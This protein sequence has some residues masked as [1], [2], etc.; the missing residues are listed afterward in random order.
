MRSIA[1]CFLTALSLAASAIGVIVDPRAATDPT[2]GKLRGVVEN[3]GVC[4]TTPG[5]YQASGYG[6]IS[7][8][9]S[10]WFW[11]FE[12]RHNPETAPLT[13]WIQGEGGTSSMVGLLTKNG[14]CRLND[15]H[16]S[17]SLNP[18]SFNEVSNVLYIDQPVGV[19]FSYGSRNITTTQA[20]AADMWEF[21]QIFFA[22]SRFTKYQKNDFGLWSERYGGN[23][24]STFASYFLTQNDAIDAGTVSGV[25]INVKNVGMGGPYMDPLLQL[26]RFLD[27]AV[28]NPYAQLVSASTILQ[29]TRLWFAD[30]NSGIMKKVQSCYAGNTSNNQLVC[31]DA[32]LAAE[33]NYYRG[34]AGSFQ[35][36]HVNSNSTDPSTE[37]FFSNGDVLA[38]IG[39][40]SEYT[41][42]NIFVSYGWATTGA[43]IRN[44]RPILEGLINKGILVG[45]WSGDADFIGNYMVTEILA[46]GLDTPATIEFYFTAFS[47][48]KVGGQQ[49]GQFIQLPPFNYVRF[50]GAGHNLGDPVLGQAEGWLQFFN[51]TIHGQTIPSR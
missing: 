13:V 50:Y 37:T 22:D 6:D 12:A 25:K 7:A 38:R 42:N 27:Y 49:V 44:S 10:I 4:E 9:G 39:A 16:T 32:Q 47:P 3:S 28:G 48:Y 5:V 1:P 21:L 15:D 46:S 2:P 30:D 18:Y 31:W 43:F 29:R 35:P 24:V 17:V 33:Q 36:F 41:E 19:G 23:L 14:P 11:F 40:V 34:L 26:P 51:Q 20:A 8:D 45:M